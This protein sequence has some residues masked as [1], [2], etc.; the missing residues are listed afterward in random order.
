VHKRALV[1]FLLGLSLSAV[2]LWYAFRGVDLAAM[3]V[4]IGRVGAAWVLASVLGCLLSL[5]LRAFRWRFLLDR[6]RPIELWSLVSA[7]FIGI[8]GNNLL[9]ARLGELVRAWLLARREQI[10]TPTVLASIVVER[11]LDAIALIA[12]LG[13]ALAAS[14]SL[15]GHGAELLRQAGL[16]GVLLS[17][18][19]VLGLTVARCHHAAILNKVDQ[20]GA[21]EC[22][23]VIAR[24]LELFRRFLEGLCV[25][26]NRV[27][28]AAVVGLSFVIWLAGI[29][30]FHVLAYGFGLGLTLVQSTLVFVIVLFGIAIP[31]APGYVGTFHGFCVAGLALVA[32]TDTMTSAAYAT[33]LHGSQWA[34]INAVGLACLLADRS[35][36]W[37][38]MLQAA[39]TAEKVD[40]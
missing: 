12:I 28:V 33:L 14:S 1:S 32:G 7:T 39:G 26:R 8:M 11:L 17:A 13:L 16:I 30:S 3:A 6:T 10:H 18:G 38:S 9:P 5:V 31:S 36:S 23:P 2:C 21:G 15:N 37:R 4:G 40:A 35:V 19:G 34:A 24:A 29:A 22:R 25:L 20:W 27:Q